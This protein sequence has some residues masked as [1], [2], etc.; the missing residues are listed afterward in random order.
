MINKY[1]CLQNNFV[2]FSQYAIVPLRQ[3]SMTF[4]K[5]WRNA[6]IDVLRQNKKLT[7]YDQR[8]YYIE[9]VSR[10]FNTLRPSEIL[11]DILFNDALIGYGGLVHIDWENKG[12]EIS[13]LLNPARLEN[14]AIY[15]KDF[16]AFIEMI[17]KVGF[18]DLHFKKLWTETYDIRPHHV[19]IL[20]KSGFKK[21]ATKRNNNSIKGKLVDSLF[22]EC[23]EVDYEK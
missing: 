22:H 18:K 10:G 2:Q 1:T 9:V 6:Q 5:E 4:I 21:V 17:K 23:L 14:K 16:S 7:D 20:E 3:E 19:S 11:F 12:C 8:R 13:F 15:E